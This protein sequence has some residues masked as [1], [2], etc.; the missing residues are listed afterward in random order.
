[1]IQ[2]SSEWHEHRAKHFNASE[3]GAVMAV[4]PWFPKNPA[5]L[6]DLK[7]GVQEVKMNSSM[8]H[9]IET[10]P[11]A[12]TWAEGALGDSMT[13]AVYT[14]GRYSASLDGINFD[15]TMGI[16]I[17]CPS[18][19]S[20]LFDLATPNAVRIGAP[21]Y[22]WQMV[23]Q[24]YCVPSLVKLAFV[25]YSDTRQ[26]MVVINRDE[27]VAHFDAL[28]AAWEMFGAALDTD[29]RPAEEDLDD[30][31][32]YQ[33]L[34]HAYRVEKLRL[35]AQEKQ[36]KAVEEELKAYAKRSGK[37]ALKGF[38]ATVT[39]VTRQGNVEYRKI[40]ELQGVDLEKY[41]GKSTTY[42]MIKA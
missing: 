19:G 14:K 30:S 2:G 20:K 29:Q 8:Q 32:E 22:W 24:F 16:E 21:H 1:M 31:E 38:G 23:H 13:P 41:R 35:E 12:R 15:N 26:N 25:V 9:G 4:S 28:C 17:K 11:K 33:Q 10:E 27:V 18:G 5:Q 7:K 3:A 36:L 6:Y 39:Q 42:W 37:T 40:P 34:V